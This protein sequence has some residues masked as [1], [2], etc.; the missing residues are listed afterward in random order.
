MVLTRKRL[1]AADM[2]ASEGTFLAVSPHVI[3]ETTRPIEALST[4]FK[5][6]DILPITAGLTCCSSCAVVFVVGDVIFRSIAFMVSTAGI[7]RFWNEEVVYVFIFV[8]YV[9]QWSVSLTY[10]RRADGISI[11]DGA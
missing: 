11:R 1:V 2:M 7:H 3:L 4:T 9:C 8:F 6:A 5:V 10:G